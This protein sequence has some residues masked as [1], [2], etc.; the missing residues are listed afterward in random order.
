M[1]RVENTL[2]PLHQ[3]SE[4]EAL[5][6]NR[7][8][9][10]LMPTNQA[11]L[12][13]SSIQDPAQREVRNS[14]ETLWK[15]V[16]FMKFWTGE[17]ISLF[18]SQVTILALPLT[19]MFILNVNAEQ[20]GL[21]RFLE[22]APYLLLPLL[23]GAWVDHYQRRPLMI[24]ANI[25]RALLIGLI[26][27]FA[28]WHVLNVFLLSSIA[29]GAG[30]FTV[31]FE[32]CWLSVIP[33]MVSKEH[34]VEA[35]SK[36]A[37]SSAAAEVAGPGLAG[38]LVQLLGAPLALVVD[39]VSYVISV[40]SLMLIRQPEPVSVTTTQQPHLIK[41]IAEG[42]RFVFQNTYIS[43]LAFGAALWNFCFLFT[44]TI[45]LLYAIRQ[46][47]FSS[48][49]LGLVYAIGAI[50]GLL[51]PVLA[52]A[53]GRRFRL[54]LVLCAT[55]VLGSIPMIV[56]PA[57]TGPQV[58]TTA[59]C[60]TVFFLVQT[61]VG[62]FNVLTIS[63]RQAVTPNE[64]MG[65]VNAGSRM[66]ARSGA[67]LGTLAAGFFGT[68]IGLR[69]SLWIAG[70]GFLLYLLPIFLSPIPKLRALSSLPSTM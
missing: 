24:L 69:A 55:S 53:L 17:T 67:M 6:P 52:T 7:L 57:I 40:V 5:L 50:G 30:I 70:G 48:S 2:S 46:L 15:N 58:L 54:G 51:G 68:F 33:T 34:L 44:D 13:A 62:A 11:P 61:A 39:S 27:L 22:N 9:G 12:E 23:F 19:A 65:R 36:V 28:F 47:H 64:L 37:T 14:G 16:D 63:L 8:K 35:N 20:L 1:E 26:P 18:G 29:F 3:D 45:F 59:V 49:L 43:A 42:L 10:F 21:L 41:N 56:L 32:V 60:S 25:V 38:F 4:K 31:L 66:I